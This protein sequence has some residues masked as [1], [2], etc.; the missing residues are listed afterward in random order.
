LN[1]L[2]EEETQLMMERLGDLQTW[3]CLYACHIDGAS[4]ALDIVQEARGHIITAATGAKNAQVQRY[5]NTDN[6]TDPLVAVME[7]LG[8]YNAPTDAENL[9]AAL[10]ACGLEIK[11]KNNDRQRHYI[12][13]TANMLG[14]SSASRQR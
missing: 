1:A 7:K 8:W 11:E 9:R 13:R 14:A 5:R 2:P 3:L 10:E 4:D 6:G 12:R